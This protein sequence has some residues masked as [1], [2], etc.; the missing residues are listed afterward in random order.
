MALPRGEPPPSRFITSLSL[1]RCAPA[2][3]TSPRPSFEGGFPLASMR[4]ACTRSAAMRSTPNPLGKGAFPKVPARRELAADRDHPRRR[5]RP[6]PQLLP[7]PDRP[8]TLAHRTRL[9]AASYTRTLDHPPPRGLTY[10]KPLPLRGGGQGGG[11]SPPLPGAT[12]HSDGVTARDV[13]N[14]EPPPAP[15]SRGAFRWRRSESRALEER[16]CEAPPTPL[17]RGLSEWGSEG[18]RGNQRGS[19]GIRGDQRESE[20]IRG[21]QRGSEGIRG[22]G[23]ILKLGC[24]REGQ[25]TALSFL[26]ARCQR[27]RRWLREMPRRAESSARAVSSMAPRMRSRSRAV[28]VSRPRWRRWR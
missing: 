13:M 24:G 28:R 16:R 15:R 14:L 8:Q 2:R 20:G 1:I 19:G 3:G 25:S 21:N 5:R 9:C 23:R 22:V 12:S 11:E 6:K 17:E 18:I 26:A 7:E 10:E 27:T 4:V